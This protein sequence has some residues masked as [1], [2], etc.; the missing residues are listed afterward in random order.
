M[1]WL[2]IPGVFL[3]VLIPGLIQQIRGNHELD[4]EEE[5]D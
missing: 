2:L 5:E 3:A 1:W 4:D